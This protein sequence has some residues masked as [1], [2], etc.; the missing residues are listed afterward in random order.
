[1]PEGK[2]RQKWLD[3]KKMTTLLSTGQNN[4][5]SRTKTAVANNNQVQTLAQPM[6]MKQGAF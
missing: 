6:I 3:V 1:M 5:R 2:K 4:R